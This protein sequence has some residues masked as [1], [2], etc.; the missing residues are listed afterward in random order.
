MARGPASPG[1]QATV[2]SESYDMDWQGQK[3]AELIMQYALMAAAVVAFMVGYIAG[4]FQLMLVVYG[5]L[6]LVVLLV[7]VPDWGCFNRHPLE[8]LDP[9]LA[10][11][12]GKTS[13]KTKPQIASKKPVKPSKK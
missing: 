10:D 4:S 2:V 9:K 7:V 3:L 1:I 12:S 11:T 5:V 13:H 8:W 6:V